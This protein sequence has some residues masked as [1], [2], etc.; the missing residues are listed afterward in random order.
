[1]QLHHE[2]DW[3][4]PEN[5]RAGGVTAETLKEIEEQELHHIKTELVRKHS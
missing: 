3:L 5:I 1:L 4:A 2:I